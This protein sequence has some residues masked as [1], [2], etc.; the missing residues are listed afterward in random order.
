VSRLW[1]RYFC[2]HLQQSIMCPHNTIYVSSY[3]YMCLVCGPEQVYLARTNAMLD[4]TPVNESVMAKRRRGGGSI[5]E[6]DEVDVQLQER[7]A[8]EDLAFLKVLRY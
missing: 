1:F 6:T 7:N 3:C 5:F 8:A 2:R 4:G